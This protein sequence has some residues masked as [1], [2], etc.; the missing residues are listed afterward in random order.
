MLIDTNTYIGHWGFRPL[1]WHTAD[2]LL[3]AMDAHG[4]DQ[5]FVSSASAILYRN[6]HAGNEELAA[7]VRGHAD[8]LVPFAVINPTYA[9]WEHDLAVCHEEFGCRGLRL[10]PNYHRYKLGDRSGR[11]L[12]EKAV[13]RK[14]I[15]SVPLRV[16][17]GRQRSWLLDVPDVTAV[18]VADAA[19]AH[20]GS[21]WLPVN[22]AGYARTVFSERN[23]FDGDFAIE[24]SRLPIGPGRDVP[25]LI[26]QAG[27]EHLAFGSGM[28]FTVPEVPLVKLEALD[29]PEEVKEAIRW[30]NAARLLG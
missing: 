20:P 18:E 11:A 10:Y 13:A 9:D 14:L 12:L 29:A 25:L 2:D 16:E 21:R 15:L 23:G 4:I 3:R 30:K 24:I 19:K 1:P 28:P 22:G 6:S 17:D 26:E 5:A 7:Q 27:P 8:R